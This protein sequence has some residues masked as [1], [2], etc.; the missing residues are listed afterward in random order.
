[1]GYRAEDFAVDPDIRR[2]EGLPAAAF[3]DPAF[4]ALEL[5]TV[6]R[7]S[8]LLVPE[9]AGAD[10]ASDGR[11]MAELCS[12]R[13]ARVPFTLLGR[14]LFLQRGW[15]DDVL[16]CFS[17][18]CTH[19]WYPLVSGP[20]RGPTLVCGQ[21]GRKFDCTGRFLAQAGFGAELPG[22]P[23]DC[24]H[25]A[26]LAVAGWRGLSFVRERSA[27][28]APSAPPTPSADGGSLDA[29]LAEVT[30][31]T[32]LLPLGPGALRR[33]R[34]VAEAREVAGNWKQHVWN[35]MDRFH[36]GFIHRAPGGLADICDMGS[37]TTELHPS[38]ALQWVYA[39]HRDAGFDPAL[40]PARFHDP[41]GRRVFAL[42]WLL[43]PNVALNFYPWGL[44]VNVF[45][46]VPERPDTTLFRWYHLVMDEARYQRR[47]E[48][49]LMSQ[50]DGEDVDAMAQVR[51]SL[52]EPG[53]PR[54][55]FAPGEETG[56][57]WFH[58]RL[59]SAVFP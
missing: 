49:W 8:W 33:S 40:L 48:S 14:P 3:R 36:V 53:L 47:E 25:L 52:R 35:Y 34:A 46:P 59:F 30:A 9:A 27:P 23:R 44:S 29:L 45:E 5:E 58:R 20:G 56:P 43:F 50:V 51:R 41:A 13:G 37:Y 39:R 18:V 22:F 17:N 11:S 19:A 7:S 12:A 55:R 32:A 16:R 54:G 57:H 38:S 6:F 31:S 4:L 1:M 2:A 42:W 15:D 28:S 26:T 10:P 21:H 24:D